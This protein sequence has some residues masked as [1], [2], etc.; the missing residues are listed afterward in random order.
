M[1]Q[2]KEDE[3]LS[4][5]KNFWE[6]CNFPN[7]VGA[8]DGKH[9][10]IMKP[11]NSGSKFYNYKKYFSFVLLAVVD[12]NYS[13][14]YIDI[15]SY[16]SSSD[17]SIF[18]HSSFGQMLRNNELDLPANSPLPGTNGPPVPYVFLGDEAFALSEHLLRPY[19][20]RNLNMERRVFNYRL[21]RGRRVVECAFGLLTNKWR[22]LHGLINLNREN[23]ICAVKAACIL[24][25]FVRERDGVAFEEQVM[26]NMQR[27]QWSGSRGNT[28]GA[29]VRD[30]FTNYFMTAG[31]VPWQLE[32]IENC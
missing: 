26:H 32:A 27:A 12:A 28:S 20:S 17:S 4:I 18:A 2:P 3:R 6:R 13:F 11:V 19:S 15:G 22:F 10:R 5:S 16:G 23:A 8:I 21:T 30:G 25:N 14:R 31:Q 9:V 1:A 7:C 24:H 29:H